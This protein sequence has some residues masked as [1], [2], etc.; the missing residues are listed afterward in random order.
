MALIDLNPPINHAKLKIMLHIY[1]LFSALFIMSSMAWDATA[2]DSLSYTGQITTTTTPSPPVKQ[3]APSDPSYWTNERMRRAKPIENNVFS[4]PAPQTPFATGDIPNNTP[5][6]PPASATTQQP[7]R[8][9]E[10][11]PARLGGDC[12][13]RSQGWGQ[14]VTICP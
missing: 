4:P 2:A 1:F 7:S 11:S 10:S 6:A 12:I 5:T 14:Y 8:S 9:I 3:L 13:T